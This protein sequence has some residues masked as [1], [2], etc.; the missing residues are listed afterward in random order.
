MKMVFTATKNGYGPSFEGVFNSLEK[1]KKAIVE[2][3]TG[4]DHYTEELYRDCIAEDGFEIYAV[5]L[6]DSEE[7][8]FHH[9]RHCEEE[10]NVNSWF[11]IEKK[12]K[13]RYSVCFNLTTSTVF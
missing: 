6:D 1:L 8:I 13:S 12:D 4:T 3:S 7:I 9:H 2:S 10:W 5:D 11:T